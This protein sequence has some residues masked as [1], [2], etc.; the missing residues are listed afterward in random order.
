MRANRRF[1]RELVQKGLLSPL[2]LS[3]RGEDPRVGLLED[4]RGLEYVLRNVLHSFLYSFLGGKKRSTFLL[5][6]LSPSLTDKGV[7]TI[8][9]IYARLII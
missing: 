3:R 9:L 8:A 4:L 6:I 5:P 1:N 2:D 7:A